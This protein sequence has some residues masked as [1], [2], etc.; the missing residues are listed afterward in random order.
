MAHCACPLPLRWTCTQCTTVLT[1]HSVHASVELRN[2]AGGAC[3]LVHGSDLHTGNYEKEVIIVMMVVV[4]DELKHLSQ[5]QCVPGACD[6]LVYLLLCCDSFF[7][8]SLFFP[9]IIRVTWRMIV[10]RV[11]ACKSFQLRFPGH[12]QHR[13][14]ARHPAVRR[15]WRV[16]Y[17]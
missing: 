14:R 4:I 12:G 17:A 9:G 8:V 2:W 11:S 7:S 1:M 5:Q 13:C 10:A 16:R 3:S 6:C 15:A